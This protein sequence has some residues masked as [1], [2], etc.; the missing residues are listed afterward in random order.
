M[1]SVG[2]IFGMPSFLFELCCQVPCL[3]T[4]SLKWQYMYNICSKTM[5]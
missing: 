4:E 3:C 1:W 2:C 5:Q